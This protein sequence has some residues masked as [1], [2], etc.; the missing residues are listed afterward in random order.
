MDNVKTLRDLLSQMTGR[1]PPLPK[2]DAPEQAEK[3]MPE[4][5]IGFSQFNEIL[6]LLGYNRV[7]NSFFQFLLDGKPES[8]T[9]GAFTS[10]EDIKIGIDRFR[11]LAM[12]FYGNIHYA[13]QHMSDDDPKELISCYSRFLPKDENVFQNRH[14]P[15]RHIE[16]I[17]AKDAYFLGYIIDGD[18]D[19]R[20]KENPDDEQALQT[21]KEMTRIRDIGIRN[22]EAYLTWDHMDIYVATS[23]R[24]H[25]QFYSIAKITDKIFKD[26]R[27]KSMKLRWFDPTQAFCLSRLD[28]GLTEALMLKRANCT[29]YLVQESDSFGKDSELASTLAQGKTVVAFVPKPES[30]DEFISELKTMWQDLY[31]ERVWKEILCE[32]LRLFDPNLAWS[33]MEIRKWL[34]DPDCLDDEVIE[35]K[36]FKTAKDV[37]DSRA[38]LLMKIHPL[39]LQVDIES[40]VACGVLVVRT[41]SQCVELLRS[42]II[43]TLEFVIESGPKT[44]V[45]G[46]LLLRET[47]SNSVARVVTGDPLLTN[48]FWNFY[49]A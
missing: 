14:E 25:H 38:N 36:L 3:L 23:M 35:Q 44:A 1:T 7:S 6:L 27:L 49:P 42:I 21:R 10:L 30:L 8:E 11:V 18:I 22:H 34:D 48:S 12:W 20:L 24:E 47:I 31:P 19:R 32:Q 41:P 9:D 13:F 37:Y 5:G 15:V 16:S 28:K 40:G 43:Q 29:L 45:Q 39:A 17:E 2:T 26:D 33:D 46:T 4:P